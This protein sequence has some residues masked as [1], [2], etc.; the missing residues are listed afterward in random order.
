MFSYI[1]EGFTTEDIIGLISSIKLEEIN[2]IFTVGGLTPSRTIHCQSGYSNYWLPGGERWCHQCWYSS[3]PLN[4][5]ARCLVSRYGKTLCF[6]LTVGLIVQL[7][8]LLPTPLTA[9]TV[10]VRWHDSD[11]IDRGDSF[12]R[13]RQS[14]LVFG[15]ALEAF[16]S[17]ILR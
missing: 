4:L 7:R 11:D 3:K 17:G 6:P 2:P 8:Y 9:L 10:M 14:V 15:L 5:L 13:S 12:L 16:P 1:G